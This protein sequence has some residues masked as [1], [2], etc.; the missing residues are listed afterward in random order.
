[1]TSHSLFRCAIA[2]RMLLLCATVGVCIAHASAQTTA[3]SV[4]VR[5]SYPLLGNTHITADVNGDGRLDLVATGGNVARVMLGNGDSTFQPRV[6]HLLAFPTQSVAAGDFNSDLRTDLAVTLNDPNVGLAVLLGTG[7]GAFGAPRYLANAAGADAPAI[8]ATDLNNDGG[9]DLVVSH[10]IAAWQAPIIVHTTISVLMGNGDGTFQPARLSS[11][12]TGMVAM[13]V[14]DFNRDGLK[15]LAIAGD[16]GRAYLLLGNGDGSFVQQTITLVS[17][18]PL[19]VDGTDVG[20][21]DLNADGAQDVVVVIGLN[22]SRTALLFGNGDG[23]FRAPSIL[24]E[25]LMWVPQ[26]QAIADYN[27]DGR[28]DLALALGDGTW[29]LFNIRHGNGDGTFQAPVQYEVPPDK[30]SIGG[31]FLVTGDFNADTR[32]DLALQIR[33]ATPGLAILVNATGGAPTA[34]VTVSSVSFSPSTVTG[35]NSS[36]GTVRLSRAVTSASAV[37]LTSNNAAAVAPQ[38]VT[39]AA[40]A[41]TASF[42]LTTRPVTATTT[43]TVT[44]ALNGVTRS[45]SVTVTPATATSDRVTITR[46]E[47]EQ[48]KH[49]LRLEA[50]SA[51]ASATLKA[52]VTATGALIGTLANQGGGK[53]G[54][55]F[56]LS[57]NPS[58][59]T[60][61]SSLGGSAS[62]AVTLK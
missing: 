35:G 7:N 46:A 57:S 14:G 18:F 29:G 38:S 45:A 5:G 23:T 41:S 56:S 50:T 6:E 30:S 47:Y 48:S 28:L 15:D 2:R 21:A 9:L 3:S 55:N 60:V 61:R 31:G 25:P 24:T 34:P 59:V 36:T 62:R 20:V 51:S 13:A 58:N 39:V 16:S 4:F 53:Y 37:S 27:R 1:M 44:A 42:T 32:P 33:G 17:A 8:V 52:Y 54:G 19:G 43:A 49:T 26:Y 12:G 22:G 11:V 10:T 40:G